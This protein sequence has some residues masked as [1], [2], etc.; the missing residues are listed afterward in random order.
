MHR[1]LREAAGRA[2]L[3]AAGLVAAVGFLELFLRLVD[4]LGQ[5]LRG[6]RLI[7]PANTRVVL[8]QEANPKLDREIVVTRNSLGFRGPDP[9]PDFDRRLTLVAV[10]GSTTECRFLGDGSDWPA[11]LSRELARSLDGLWVNNAGLDG[12]SSFGHLKLVEQRLARLRPRVALLLMGLNDV[13]RDDPKYQDTALTA[14]PDLEGSGRILLWA[15]RRSA[16]VSLAWNAWR[17]R[18][19][20]RLALVQPVLDLASL[21]QD[22]SGRRGRAVARAHRQGSARAYRERVDA[23]LQATRGAGIEPVLLTQPALYGPAQDDVTGVDLGA[24]VVDHQGTNGAVAWATLEAYNDVL[25][26]LGRE[27][28]VP[29][30]DVARRLPKSSRLY[31]DL[32]HL[33]REGAAELGR[34]AAA[35]LCPLLAAR[36]PAHAARACP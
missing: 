14:R 29:L 27:Q 12:H 2:A 26:E 4:P 5:R 22:G 21:P 3:L 23:L 25:R 7:L 9:P 1:A 33:T 24:I 10:G 13:A 16:A 36:F 28:G 31:Y 8:T 17:A 35:D 20:E 19:A 32:V 15:A 11:A 30:L 34:I 18:Q 6:D